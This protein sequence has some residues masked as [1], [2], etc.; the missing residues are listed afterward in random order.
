M[1]DYEVNKVKN[2]KKKIKT[3]MTDIW[4]DAYITESS[5]PR[6]WG[7][8]T[9]NIFKSVTERLQWKWVVPGY[10]ITQILTNHGY[11]NYML[12]KQDISQYPYCQ[13]CA[14]RNTMKIDD[15]NHYV[16]E[17]EEYEEDRQ[18]LREYM[19]IKNFSTLRDIIGDRCGYYQLKKFIHKNKK[20]DNVVNTRVAM[21][22]IE[23]QS[24]TKQQHKN[25][26][27]QL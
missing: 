15:A 19:T 7:K 23:D 20:L 8:H 9:R 14:S 18:A 13:T 22:P 17:C 2:Y 16:L 6:C 5:N 12:H 21:V 27:L 10:R 1:Y 11:F 26:Y 24:K 25:K 3:W 4:N